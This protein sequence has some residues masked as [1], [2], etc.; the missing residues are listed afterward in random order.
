MTSSY[1]V[2]E[3]KVKCFNI[4]IVDSNINI[5]MIIMY[6]N[7]AGQNKKQKCGPAFWGVFGQFS[8]I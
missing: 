7:I 8:R 3:T 1:T 2:S 6:G 5:F 4:F